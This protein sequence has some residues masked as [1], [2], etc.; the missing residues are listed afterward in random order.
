MRYIDEKFKDVSPVETVE[1]IKS[2]LNGIGIELIENWHE[3]GVENCHSLTLMDSTKTVFSNGKGVT[4]DFAR[5]SAYA[6]FIERL[7]GG[8]LLIKYQSIY[9]DPKMN[10][11]SYAPDKKYQTVDELVE[12]G[13][14]MDPIIKK[15]NSPMVNRKSIASLC[16]VYDCSKDGKVLTV[17]FYSLFEKKHVYLPMGFVDQIYSTNGCC[18][19]NSREEA[20]VHAFS[21]IL[22]RNACIELMRNGKSIPRISDDILSK[23]P[24][25]TKIIDEI[26]A[27]G[28]YDVEIFDATIVAD[29]PV[30]STRVINKKTHSYQIN[31]AADPVLEIA[32]QR[33]LT[34]LL[35]GA[36]V[37]S[38]A[39]KHDGRVLN[40]VAVSASTNN[41]INQLETGDGYFTA[42]YFADELTCDR[43]ATDFTDNSIRT[44]KE[45]LTYA[46][47]VFRK[48]GYPVYVRNF[49]FLGFS[50]YR[51]V[52]PG[53]SEAL[54]G[55]ISDP[56]PEYAIADD[57]RK[58]ALDAGSASDADL[59]MMLFYHNMISGV[60]SKYFRFDKFAGL[61]MQG[62]GI[63]LACVVRAYAAYRLNKFADAVTY[64]NS[65]ICSSGKNEEAKEYFRCVNKFIELRSQGITEDKIRAILYKFFLAEYP[66]KLFRC[67]DNGLTP[68]EDYLV[69]CDFTNCEDCNYKDSCLRKNAEEIHRIAGERYMEFT[70]GQNEEEFSI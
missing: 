11:Q 44:N 40:K 64:T 49:S 7:Q 10:L 3:S 26:R 28:E 18:A 6:E 60:Y 20:W 41:I 38:L 16:A 68:Y 65:Y 35:Q 59:N 27:N 24:V 5:A 50:C 43:Q 69:R 37:E 53:F 19:G 56:V 8:L 54:L 14:W 47:D 34:E 32:L 63:L 70:N 1:K 45:L 29:Y 66:D 15:I 58:V 51:F 67:L 13:E 36:R 22:E 48:L 25:V 12:N 2:L 21:E 30:V 23:Y 62:N 33:S 31:F 57:A 9:S 46:L 39:T 42:D 4:K 55:N 17:P 61:P 52:V